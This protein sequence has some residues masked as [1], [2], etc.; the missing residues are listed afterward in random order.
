MWS[1][2]FRRRKFSSFERCA[3]PRKKIADGPS[4]SIV[5][6]I[7]DAMRSTAAGTIASRTSEPS[8]TVAFEISRA[9]RLSERNRP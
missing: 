6:R 3:D 1:A 7:S 4:V 2:I 9:F 8:R 5:E